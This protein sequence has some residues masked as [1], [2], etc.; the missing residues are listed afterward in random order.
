MT[1]R[2]KGGRPFEIQKEIQTFEVSSWRGERMK[3]L[4]IKNFLLIKTLYLFHIK[5][6]LPVRKLDLIKCHLSRF[7]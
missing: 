5:V 1:D 7:T 4:V 3:T 6:L 2:K